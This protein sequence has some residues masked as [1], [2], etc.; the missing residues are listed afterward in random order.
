MVA[1]YIKAFLQNTHSFT[2]SSIHSFL[3]GYHVFIKYLW[4]FYQANTSFVGSMEYTILLPQCMSQCPIYCEVLNRCEEIEYLQRTG[5][6]NIEA[7]PHLF[8]LLALVNFRLFE[9][10]LPHG[11][12]YFPPII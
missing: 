3:R 10:L 7:G 6:T 9:S 4:S 12:L 11:Y 1:F 2:H 8:G 5:L